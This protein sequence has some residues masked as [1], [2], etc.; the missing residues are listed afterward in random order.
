[1]GVG[2]IVGLF[3]LFCVVF[4]GFEGLLRVLSGSF[5]GLFF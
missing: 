3:G 5:G 4:F 2:I 1:M